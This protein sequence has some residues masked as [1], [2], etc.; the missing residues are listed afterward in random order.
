MVKEN[1]YHGTDCSW[2][3][4]KIGGNEKVAL[5]EKEIIVH[6]TCYNTL[7]KYLAIDSLYRKLKM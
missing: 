4:E 2:C 3:L 6:E 1:V 7:Y 5:L